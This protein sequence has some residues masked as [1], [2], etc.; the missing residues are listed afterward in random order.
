MRVSAESR[1]GVVQRVRACS[2]PV[3]VRLQYECG[4]PVV[5]P[6]GWVDPGKLLLGRAPRVLRPPVGLHGLV[7]QQQ[8]LLGLEGERGIGTALVV[9]ELDLE[10]V[11]G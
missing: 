4:Q 3:A 9:G 6:G 2:G 11:R 7:M 8:E 10:H 5:T 1:D